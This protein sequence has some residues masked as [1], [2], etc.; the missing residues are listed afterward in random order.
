MY[1]YVYMRHFY[2]ILS[3]DFHV[4]VLNVVSIIVFAAY[5]TRGEV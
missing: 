1:V 4:W 5:D 2:L 3:I